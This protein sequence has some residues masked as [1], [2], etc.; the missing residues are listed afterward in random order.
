MVSWTCSLNKGFLFVDKIIKTSI[1]DKCQS[2]KQ[3]LEKFLC[4]SSEA[5]ASH[6]QKYII[7]KMELSDEFEIVLI[8]DQLE[9]KSNCPLLLIQNNYFKNDE[10]ILL[11]F[12]IV[13]KEV[14]NESNSSQISS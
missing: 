4:I 14:S 3:L 5:T 6:I 13:H 2:Y 9:I 11:H 1:D 10:K 7:N 8:H 12:A